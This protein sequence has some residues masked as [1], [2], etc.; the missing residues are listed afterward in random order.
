[1]KPPLS[2]MGGKY[3]LTDT[4]LNLIPEHNTYVEVFGGAGH[5][6][7]QKKP[8]EINIYNDINTDLVTFFKVLQDKDK[9]LQLLNLIDVTPYSRQ[10]FN[11]IRDNLYI[12]PNLDAD[13]LKAYKLILYM[14]QAFASKFINIK[15]T[16]SYTIQKHNLA[17]EWHRLP[18]KLYPFIDVLKNILIENKDFRDLIQTYDY[19]NCLF[20]CDPP[21]YDR[22]FYYE[23]SFSEQDHI[24]L[25]NILNNVKGKVLLSYYFFDKIE[26]LYPINKWRYETKQCRISAKLTKDTQQIK[27]IEYILMNYE[28]TDKYLFR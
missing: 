15:P 19:E 13:I 3:H 10:Y 22:E 21:Y 1:M 14:Q 9:A 8:V 18:A 23:G 16:W 12:P 24:D 7:L 11:E 25:A 5:V 4:L 27:S 2:Y 20:Y 17:D 28:L 26:E 6:I